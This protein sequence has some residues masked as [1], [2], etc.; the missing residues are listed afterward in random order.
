M[1]VVALQLELAF[2]IERETY[3]TQLQQLGGGGLCGSLHPQF[4]G[5]VILRHGR[6]VGGVDAQVML[7]IKGDG[8]ILVLYVPCLGSHLHVAVAG[9]V[10][11]DGA[12]AL[13]HLPVA[14]EP[15]CG[16]GLRHGALLQGGGYVARLVPEEEFV[17]GTRH[18]LPH[19][20]RAAA[21]IGY[22]FQPTEECRRRI[23]GHAGV[24]LAVCRQAQCQE[25]PLVQRYII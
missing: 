15:L 1:R 11:D 8:L 3:L 23:G 20:E 5:V 7:A 22:G 17:H 2:G 6:D 14:D 16:R 4:Y 19:D 9:I 25:R 13:V 12:F 21:L 10:G 18:L 24:Q